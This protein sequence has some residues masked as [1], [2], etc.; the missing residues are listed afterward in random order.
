[1]PR[2][3]RTNG[4]FRIYTRDA[5]DRVRLIRQAQTVG[6]TLDE[7]QELVRGLD[8]G[9]SE[10]L[11]R[12]TALLVARLT[13]V[14]AKLGELR[15]FRRTLKGYLRKPAGSSLGRDHSGAAR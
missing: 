6:L 14:D 11:S 12:V 5:L 10:E 7:V 13:E 4:G 2:S 8:A 9:E 15:E 1:L 3:R